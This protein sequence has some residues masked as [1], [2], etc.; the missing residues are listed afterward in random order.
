MNVLRMIAAGIM[1][2]LGA[3]CGSLRPGIS[4]VAPYEPQN[5][6]CPAGRLPDQFRRV[7]L[8]PLANQTPATADAAVSELIQPILAAELRKRNA[9]EVTTCSAREL[10]IWTGRETLTA[11]EE[12]PPDLLQRLQSH[13]G[14]DGI[15][16]AELTHYHAY[17]PLAVG[18]NLRLVECRTGGT[19]WSVDET[20][21][22]G[23]PAV[24][25]GARAFGRA[26][27]RQAAETDWLMQNSPRHFAQ[28]GVGLLLSTLPAQTAKGS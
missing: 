18:L 1:L 23:V 26:E 22:G 21:D 14:C 16:F 10:K 19:I 2:V 3:G 9:F 28:Y 11:G 17:P 8:L 27:L 4:G 24:A 25:A 12:L 20:L 6:Y 15:L 5:I 7:L 13:T